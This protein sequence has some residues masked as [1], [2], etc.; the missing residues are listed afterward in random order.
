MSRYNADPQTLRRL[1]PFSWFS[2]GQLSWAM[3]AIETRSYERNAVI[4]HSGQEGDGLYILLEGQVSVLHEDG[5]GHQ[6]LVT[7][8]GPHEFFGELGLFE[9]QAC[10]ASIRAESRCR[11]LFVPRK[12]VLECLEENAR[13]AMCMLDKITA[14]LCQTHAKLAHLALTT[15]EQ[16]VASTLVEHSVESDGVW[17]VRVGAEQISS[18]VAA[19][20]EMVSR[21]VKRM[22]EGGIVR[23]DRRRLIVV[24]REA[25]SSLAARRL[26]A[27]HGGNGDARRPAQA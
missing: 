25:V 9:G 15:V 20:R 17:H 23:R 19:S 24:D 10:A 13:A 16:R 11:A 6:L 18:M 1:A 22:V 21:V 2:S 26:H 4:Q 27:S 14:R 3:G 12:V 8:I 7:S 5:E